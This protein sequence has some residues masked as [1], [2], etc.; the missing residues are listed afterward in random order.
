MIFMSGSLG[1]YSTEELLAMGALRVIQ[2]PF[3]ITQ[4]AE[5]LWAL[6]GERQP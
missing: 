2:K 4:F 3:S 1:K 6:L 5:T